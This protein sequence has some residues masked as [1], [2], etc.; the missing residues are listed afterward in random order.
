M[1]K[2][3]SK[4]KLDNALGISSGSS[5]DELLDTL[6]LDTAQ[7]TIQTIDKN[8]TETLSQVNSEIVSL[9]TDNS[10]FDIT[11]I[12]QQLS[13]INELIDVAKSVLTHLY[14]NIITTDVTLVD[15]ELI[16][17]T[18][19]F[20]S[21]C[22]DSIKEWIDLYKDHVKFLNK[23]QIMMLEQKHKKEL[24]DYKYSLESKLK[25]EGSQTPQN[26]RIYR[27]EDLVKLIDSVN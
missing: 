8:V 4:E 19:T 24:L 6:T 17:A 23:I 16:N 12:T 18:A 14:K 26:M 15:P 21:S 10:T 1:N 13:S 3:T 2:M 11:N 25:N 27:Q 20:I 9:S 5:F 7:T 22:R